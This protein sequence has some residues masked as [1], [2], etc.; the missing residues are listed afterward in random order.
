LLLAFVIFWAYIAYFQFF[1]IY[2]ANRP[3]EAVYFVRRGNGSWFG[4]SL[5]LIAVQ[6]V[7]PFLLLLL[8]GLKFRAGRLTA[9]AVGLLFAHY[10]DAYF[11][12]MPV[13][14][15][16][17]F[18]PHWLDLAALLAL[19]GVALCVSVWLSRGHALVPAF[20]PELALGVEYR[21]S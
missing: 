9:V 16:R 7:L 4:F 11:M 12:V 18:H 3:D 5:V 13:L 14:H 19:S 10:V 21:S 15:G 8:Y 2:I 20:D 6:F 1:L 17:G